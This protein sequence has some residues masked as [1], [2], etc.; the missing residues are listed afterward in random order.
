MLKDLAVVVSK[1]YSHSLAV[2]MFYLELMGAT[3]FLARS[4]RCP[5]L[6]KEGNIAQECDNRCNM[7]LMFIPKLRFESGR[8]S[9]IG[10]SLR[11]WGSRIVVEVDVVV[12]ET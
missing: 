4:G 8:D 1:F 7:Q 2:Y 10:I 3:L 9:D 12:E 6:Y 11:G 5:G